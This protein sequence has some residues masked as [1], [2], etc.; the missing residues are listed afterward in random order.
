MMRRGLW[1]L[2]ARLVALL[3][4]CLLGGCAAELAHRESDQLFAENRYDEGMNKL[5][6]AMRLEPGNAQFRIEYRQRLTERVGGIIADAEV[7]REKGDI[8]GARGAYQSALAL[9]RNSEAARRG[10]VNLD[11][12]LRDNSMLDEAEGLLA[13][14]NYDAARDIAGAVRRA[15]PGNARSQETL[16]KID[17]G[18]E[19]RRRAQ[20]A[21]ANAQSVLRRPVTLQFR[22]ANLR[23]VFEA[24]ARTTGLNVVFDRDVRPDLKTTIFVKDGSVEDTVDLILLQN[25]LEKKVLNGNTM[26]V[27][28]ATQ[29]K[30]KEY[31]ELK[32]R[33]FRVSNGDAK[34]I[35]GMLKSVLKIKEVQMDERSNTLVLRD[36]P[37]ALNVAARVIAAHDVADAEVMLE[38]QVMEVSRD[39]LSNLGIEWPYSFGVTPQ[40]G[41]TPIT[42]GDLNRIN[43]DKLYVTT[44][45]GVTA[46]F[47]LDDSDANILASPRIRV[48]DREK[49]KILIGDRVPT[50]TNSLTPL[51]TGA[52]VVT[53]SVQY[54]DVGIKLEA[55][56]H[57][58]EEGDV[59]IK[60]NLEVSNIVK[61]VQVESSLAY[62]IGTRA[63]STSLRL[64]DGETQI[65]GGLISD[66][67][68]SSASKIPG[69][70][71]LPVLGRLFS[72]TTGDHIKT[73]IVLSVTPHI[74]RNH[75]SFDDS[76]ADAWSGTESRL[77]DR[78]LRL[79]PINSVRGDAPSSGTSVSAPTGGA[80]PAQI[81]ATAAGTPAMRPTASAPAPA[82]LAAPATSTAPGATPAVATQPPS[83][84]AQAI[85]AMLPASLAPT[86]AAPEA[87]AAAEEHAAPPAAPSTA[88]RSDAG[89]GPELAWGPPVSARKGD[90]F[91]VS[92]DAARLNGVSSVPL[93]IQ[94][95]PAILSFVD[96]SL[97]ELGARANAVKNDPL[98]NQNAGR[99]S[100]T[101]DA[102]KDAALSGSGELLRLSFTAKLARP[103]T[104]LSLARVD[105][106]EGATLRALPRP[107]ALTLKVD[108]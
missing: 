94:Y 62:Q 59:G 20:E 36:T 17:A 33:T 3:F 43:R 9:D 104:Q 58:Y 12:N 74:V 88:P 26:L 77:K 32:V 68:R 72:N 30:E 93:I 42:I 75:G 38:V 81:A 99:I 91:S 27:Y 29:A 18:L 40:S 71:Q 78:P 103:S 108:P 66:T 7:R 4:C 48:R 65:L 100:V 1:C 76:S 82:V 46:N 41:T 23:M 92:I 55:E 51:A 63:A 11:E 64:R 61:Q 87:G 95:D 101:V 44:P 84:S 8:A 85:P 69:L 98:I 107:Q 70:G 89:G 54:L 35:Q 80:T 13:A 5:R 53:G 16:R 97:G 96:A 47:R 57:I 10:L 105:L 19:A 14:G 67:D 21:A 106:K 6:E 22:D 15:H 60:L 34:Y 52:S 90:T 79:D 2:P 102:A 86:Q 39:R 50:F 37:E 28:P 24:L 45:L 56:P 73:E 31:Q 49:A 25:Q 83:A